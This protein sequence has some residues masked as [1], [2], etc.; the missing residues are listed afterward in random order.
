M[1]KIYN[2]LLMPLAAMLW[3]CSD[4]VIDDL[5]GTYDDIYR[6]NYT[7]ESTGETDKLKKGLKY[8]HMNFSDGKDNTLFLSVVSREWTLQPGVY[9]PWSGPLDQPVANEFYA[10]TSEGDQANGRITEGDLEVNMVG[11]D[12]DISGMLTGGDGKRYVINYR[13]PI[14]FVIGVDDPEP[15]GYT[16]TMKADP[17]VIMDYTTWQS[18][19]IPGVSK[20][21]LAVSDPAGNDAAFFEAINKEGLSMSD[22]TGTYTIAGSPT[23]PWLID[24]GWLVPDYGMAGGAYIVSSTGEKQYLTQGKIN[25]ESVEGITGETLYNFSGEN[26]SYITAAG[27]SGTANFSI[28]FSS[29]LEK[30]GTELKDLSFQSEV[31]GREVKYSVILP[32]SF[33]GTKTFP[34]LYMLHGAT[35][36]NN[37]WLTG[38][39]IGSHTGS[40]GTEMIIISPQGSFDGFDSFYIDNYQS[41]GMNYETFFINEFMP[42][43]EAMYKGDG[44]RGIAGL[45]M[46]GFGSLYY[47]LKYADRFSGIYA[48]SP[49]IGI[50][51]TPNIFDMIWTPGASAITV[52]IGTEDF[53]YEVNKGLNEAMQFSPLLPVFTYIE[54]A[55]AHDWA[56][57]SACSPK[58]IKFFDGLFSK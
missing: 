30:S 5:S 53:L 44:R 32:K 6:Y 22:L 9:K 49:A 3:A 23:E 8:L 12:Y 29:Y 56:F 35:G 13:G 45:S 34:V 2:L 4:D 54:R 43:V 57:W 16:V 36:G 52:E 51:G 40:V 27:G 1:K 55:G 7:T 39:N 46:G 17:V 20:Y 25:I 15:S 19:V 50:E 26:L 31:L 10:F 18:T 21:T 11:S 14:E 37:D 47:G 28:R 41:K 33:D 38:G 24:N 48:C 42:A 58:I